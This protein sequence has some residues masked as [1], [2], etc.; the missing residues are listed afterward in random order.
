MSGLAVQAS[1]LGREPRAECK[2]EFDGGE[3]IVVRYFAR[4][5]DAEQL[6]TLRRDAAR[7]A[8]QN[9]RWVPYFGIELTTPRALRSPSQEIPAGTHRIALQM[10][11]HGALDLVLLKD[12]ELFPLEQILAEGDLHFD[13]LTIALVP[14]DH[15]PASLVWQW[16]P[17]YGKVDFF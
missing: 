12:L 3:E 8:L 14:S 17:E 4:K 11:A 13:H 5:F 16:G 9:P 2:L 1:R 15:G 6:G 7:R 10:N